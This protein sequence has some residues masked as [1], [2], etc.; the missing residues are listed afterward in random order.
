MT[1]GPTIAVAMLATKSSAVP[2]DLL[3][4][5]LCGNAVFVHVQIVFSLATTFSFETPSGNTDSARDMM[6]RDIMICFIDVKRAH[7][8]AKQP[9]NFTWNCRQRCD[10]QAVHRASWSS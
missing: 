8:S 6:I 4:P 2:R 9:G 5:I 1:P 3:W 7:L 10:K